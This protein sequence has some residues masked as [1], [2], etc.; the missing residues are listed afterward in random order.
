VGWNFKLKLYLRLYI[1]PYTIL[2]QQKFSF[3]YGGFCQAAYMSGTVLCVF[4]LVPID[5]EKLSRRM[6][7]GALLCFDLECIKQSLPCMDLA[8]GT[9]HL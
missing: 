3:V 8:R 5:I 1:L 4:I 9:S 6:G 7:G 2:S